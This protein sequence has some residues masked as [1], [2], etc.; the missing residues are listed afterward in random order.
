MNKNS[1][2]AAK[3][4]EIDN[5]VEKTVDQINT[6]QE[7]QAANLNQLSKMKI[8]LLPQNQLK[9]LLMM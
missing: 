7:Q 1:K 9:M 8:N 2:I 4:Q 3:Q 5:L 6:R